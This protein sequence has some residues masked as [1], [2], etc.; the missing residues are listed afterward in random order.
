MF[1]LSFGQDFTPEVCANS[2]SFTFASS[3]HTR[4]LFDTLK[5]VKQIKKRLSGC[6][7]KGPRKVFYFCMFTHSANESTDPESLSDNPRASVNNFRS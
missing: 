1:T 2:N 4:R 3:G 5:R 7:L 6:N